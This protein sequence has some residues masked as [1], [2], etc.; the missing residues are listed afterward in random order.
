M[1]KKSTKT[2]VLVVLVLILSG[3]TYAMA[4]ANTVASTMAG[5]GD[6]GEVSGYELTNIQYNLKADDPSIIASVTF[7]LDHA[8]KVVKIQLVNTTTAAWYA[9]TLDVA[10]TSVTCPTS[11]TVLSTNILH[12]VASST[13]SN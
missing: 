8:A 5:D 1:F 6:G 13:I 2:L 12:V 11:A 9:C 10:G 4:G 7:T 3:F